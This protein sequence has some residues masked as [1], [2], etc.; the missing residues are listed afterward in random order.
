M[1]VAELVK[2]ARFVIDANGDKK[3]VV[4][5]WA[6]WEELLT[7]LE[8]LEDAEEVRRLREFKEPAVEWNIAKQELCAAGKD[9]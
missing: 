6:I 9:V 8:D 3:A 4:V 1:S 5:D 7:L 2:Q